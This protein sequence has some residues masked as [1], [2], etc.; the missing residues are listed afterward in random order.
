MTMHPANATKE[1]MISILQTFLQL[2]S[3][4]SIIMIP[5]SPPKI[6]TWVII[7][8][9][10]AHAIKADIKNMLVPPTRMLTK[11]PTEKGYFIS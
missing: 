2:T 9:Y 8:Y 3:L 5:G 11:S 1:P 6:A 7:V 4:A 10:A